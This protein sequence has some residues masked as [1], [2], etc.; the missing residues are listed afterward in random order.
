M[1]GEE[2]EDGFMVGVDG[3]LGLGC[4]IGVHK[5]GRKEGRIKNIRYLYR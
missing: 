1:V 4:F 3:W 2:I 5:M